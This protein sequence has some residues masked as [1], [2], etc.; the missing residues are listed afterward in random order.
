MKNQT[1]HTPAISALQ[2]VHLGADQVKV[3][4]RMQ[5]IDKFR[6]DIQVL[7]HGADDLIQRPSITEI[8]T[9]VCQ[10]WNTLP[11]Q[12]MGKTRQRSLVEPR[13]VFFYLV[14]RVWAQKISLKECG[15]LLLRDHSTVLHSIKTVNNLMETELAFAAR[16]RR[17]MLLLK[18]DL[19]EVLKTK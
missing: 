7:L 8:F 15:R 1:E 2:L 16:V 6:K 3:R 9:R 14:M 18:L 19:P 5:E 12:L 4:V 10:E 11:A 17:V 13:H